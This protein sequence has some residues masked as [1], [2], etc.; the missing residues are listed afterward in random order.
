MVFLDYE[1]YANPIAWKMLTDAFNKG[2]ARPII[3]QCLK[4]IMWRTSKINVTTELNIPKQQEIIHNVTMNE[5][6]ARFYFD[7]HSKCELEFNQTVAKLTS[8]HGGDA[9][10]MNAKT[11]KLVSILSTTTALLAALSVVTKAKHFVDHGTV[12]QTS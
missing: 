1:P 8:T 3:D 7:E 11:L 9:L 2:D 6:E 10:K 12:A 4:N 5:L